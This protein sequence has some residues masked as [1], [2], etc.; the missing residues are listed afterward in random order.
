[1]KCYLTPIT[2]GSKGSKLSWQTIISLKLLKLWSHL[3]RKYKKCTIL[4]QGH[5]P[6]VKLRELAK[7]TEFSLPGADTDSLY[8]QSVLYNPSRKTM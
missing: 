7:M 6:S 3:Q 5:Y 8:M 1:M 2:S 4:V